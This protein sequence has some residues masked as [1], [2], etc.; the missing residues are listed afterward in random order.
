M[1]YRLSNSRLQDLQAEDLYN[2]HVSNR[3]QT[4]I[5]KFFSWCQAQESDRFMWLAITLFTQIGL[6]LPLTA[7]FITF[8]G[9]N[10]FVW[11]VIL[12][13]VNIPVLVLNLAAFPTKITLPFV[14]FGWLTQALIIVSCTI[15]A[16]IN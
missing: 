13:A 16:L 9:G 14:F 7:V 15:F 8:L 12:A 10:N 1:E 5:S 6:T 11:W 3:S 2:Y 4:L